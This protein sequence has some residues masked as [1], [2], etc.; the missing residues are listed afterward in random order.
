LA[1]SPPEEFVVKA[2][3]GQT[4]LYGLIYKP[5]DF[6][7]T[8]SYPV[9]DYIYNGPFISWVPRTFSDGRGVGQAALAQHGFVVF[10]VDGRGTTD[11]GKAFQDVAYRNFGRNEIPDHV[12]A[13]RAAASTR[14][15]MDLGR[16]GIYGF[17]WGGY[18]TVRAMLL[19]PDIYRVAVAG[20]GVYDIHDQNAWAIEAYMDL[21]WE[22]PEGYEYGSSLRLADRLGGKLLLMHGTSDQNA[23]FSTTMKLVEAF[24]RANKP[25]DLM[26]LPEV[27]HAPSGQ[28]GA[29]FNLYLRRYFQE[30]LLTLPPSRPGEPGR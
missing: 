9:I 29:Y 23:T 24:V 10:M 3:D 18:M 7:P 14:P 12:A 1:W 17:S 25:Y 22:N 28:S 30:H 26:I 27:D 20:A 21:P 8:R 5:H 19:E 2:A 16:V 6:D 15:W 13:L 11:R 4:D